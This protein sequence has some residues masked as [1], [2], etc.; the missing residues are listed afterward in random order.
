LDALTA[1]VLDR[2]HNPLRMGVLIG[3]IFWTQ[4]AAGSLK[5]HTLTAYQVTAYIALVL[6]LVFAYKVLE[7]WLTQ[8]KSLPMFGLIVSLYYPIGVI[9]AALFPPIWLWWLSAA[10]KLIWFMLGGKVEQPK[11]SKQPFGY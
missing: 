1:E 11:G 2:K 8:S 10:G 9:L 4:V 7:R 6:F 5:L 3:L